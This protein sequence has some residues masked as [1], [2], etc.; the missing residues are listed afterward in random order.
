LKMISDNNYK[1]LVNLLKRVIRDMPTP[2][3]NR[4][5]GETI[6]QARVL[7]KKLQK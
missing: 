4:R 6:R 5:Q 3:Q 7:L 2:Y 1:G